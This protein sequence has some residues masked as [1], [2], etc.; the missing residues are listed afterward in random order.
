MHPF[1]VPDPTMERFWFLC[2]LI[3]SALVFI[4]PL[5]LPSHLWPIIG[6]MGLAMTA[7]MARQ[8]ASAKKQRLVRTDEIKMLRRSIAD[9]APET[10]A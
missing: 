8:G 9:Q 10:S 6:G 3:M 5:L 4:C 2:A 1:D 7:L